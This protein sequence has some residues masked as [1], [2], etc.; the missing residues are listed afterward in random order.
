MAPTLLNR[1]SSGL[2]CVGL[3]PPRLFVA[4]FAAVISKRVILPNAEA[5]SA[6]AVVVIHT[7]VLKMP[8][9]ETNVSNKLE[10]HG[11]EIRQQSEIYML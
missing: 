7:L 5:H 4:K 9:V 2:S 6:F 10:N 11:Y 8:M 3:K 1:I